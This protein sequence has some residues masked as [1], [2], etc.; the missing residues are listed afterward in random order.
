MDNV[1]ETV[2]AAAQAQTAPVTE[3]PVVQPEGAASGVT[4]GPQANASGTTFEELAAKKGFKSPDDLAKAYA[5][6]E[7][8]ST[9]VAQEKS[10]LEKLFFQQPTQPEP[11]QPDDALAELDRFVSEKLSEKEKQ[12]EHKF[13]TKLAKL[14]LEKVIEKNPDFQKYASDVKDIKVRFPNMSFS[15]ALLLAKAQKGSLVAEAKSQALKEAVEVVQR[16]SQAQV[17]PEKTAAENKVTAQDLLQGASKR[18][19]PDRVGKISDRA[20]A[21]IELLEKE[22]FGGVL[23]KTSTGL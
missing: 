5:N 6:I 12:L 10:E 18:W 17:A 1:Q 19:T 15:E 9:K 7:S 16:Q 20:R 21:E 22:L 13:E 23:E 8:H 4:E 11:K 2:P 14:E 3:T